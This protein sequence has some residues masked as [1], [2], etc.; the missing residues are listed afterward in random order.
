MKLV[1]TKEELNK[2]VNN[3]FQLSNETEIVIDDGSTESDS[4]STKEIVA[5]ALYSL[6]A[7]L[8]TRKSTVT[9]GATIDSYPAEKIIQEFLDD[10][11]LSDVYADVENWEHRI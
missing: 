3:Y 8:T 10:H 11:G 5:G 7:K 9:F 2:V 6:M 1:L 4:E